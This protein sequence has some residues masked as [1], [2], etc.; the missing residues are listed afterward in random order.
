M[1]GLL[2]ELVVLQEPVQYCTMASYNQFP[3]KKLP[4]GQPDGSRWI[5]WTQS[6]HECAKDGSDQMVESVQGPYV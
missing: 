3:S 2:Q 6:W 1:K 5:A 4:A